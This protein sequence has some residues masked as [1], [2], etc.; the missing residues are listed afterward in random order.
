MGHTRSPSYMYDPHTEKA[1]IP[2]AV[3]EYSRT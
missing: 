2:A 3:T 1:S